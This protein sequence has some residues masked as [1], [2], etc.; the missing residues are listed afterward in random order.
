[1]FGVDRLKGFGSLGLTWFR[2]TSPLVT[3]AAA[4]ASLALEL[5]R[6]LPTP[7]P[8]P[9]TLNPKPGTLN[10]KPETPN[11]QTLNPKP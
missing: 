3:P 8:K 10:P 11:P 6:R 4:T 2:F 7:N 5:G 9:Q 1:M